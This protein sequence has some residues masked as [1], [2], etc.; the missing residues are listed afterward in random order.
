MNSAG[1]LERV[2]TLQVTLESF[3]PHGKQPFDSKATLAEGVP[4]PPPVHNNKSDSK[5]YDKSDIKSQLKKDGSSSTNNENSSSSSEKITDPID[6]DEKDLVVKIISR[7]PDFPEEKTKGFNAR[8]DSTPPPRG[9]IIKKPFPAI[10]V[11][12]EPPKRSESEEGDQESKAKA[13]T[14]IT[15]PT[16]PVPVKVEVKPLTVS[17]STPNGATNEAP[18]ISITFDQPMIPLVDTKSAVL[19]V[20]NSNEQEEKEKKKE[21]KKQ[22]GGPPKIQFPAVMEPKHPGRWRWIDTYTLVFEVETRFR[23]C[24]KITVKVP[25][26]TKAI[27]TTK[28]GGGILKEDHIL[29]FQTPVTNFTWRIY[30]LDKVAAALEPVIL[31]TTDHEIEPEQAFLKS[32]LQRPRF[33]SYEDIPIVRVKEVSELPA[34]AQAVLT[35]LEQDHKYPYKTETSNHWYAFKPFK[36][37][38]KNTKYRVRVSGSASI[39]VEGNGVPVLSLETTL[40]TTYQPLVMDSHS[41]NYSDWTNHAPIGRPIYISIYFN[42]SID[43][44]HF[45]P[46]MVTVDPPFE[47]QVVQRSMLV[48]SR[49][50]T[51]KGIIRVKSTSIKVSLDENITDEFGQRLGKKQGFSF[52]SQADEVDE[53]SLSQSNPIVSNEYVI[54]DPWAIEQEGKALWSC[55]SFNY[56]EFRVVVYQLSPEDWNDWSCKSN[57][58]TQPNLFKTGTLKDRKVEDKKF[59]ISALRRAKDA[60]TEKTALELG[61]EINNNEPPERVYDYIDVDLSDAFRKAAEIT[62]NKSK[63]FQMDEEETK[64]SKDEKYK[65]DKNEKKTSQNKTEKSKTSSDIPFGHLLVCIKPTKRAI[66]KCNQHKK[67]QIITWVAHTRIGISN[68][69]LNNGENLLICPDLRTGI[70]LDGISCY[71]QFVIHDLKD[72]YGPSDFVLIP[73][74]TTS[75]GHATFNPSTYEVSKLKLREEG[76]KDKAVKS[77]DMVLLANRSNGDSMFFKSSHWSRNYYNYKPEIIYT[78]DSRGLYRPKEEVI[79]RGWYRVTKNK[80]IGDPKL[81]AQVPALAYAYPHTTN[82]VVYDPLSN[83]IHEESMTI[84]DKGEIY[85][86]FVI[87]DNCNLGNVRITFL[88]HAHTIRVEEFRR[89]E[90][91][92]ESKV[93][94]SVLPYLMAPPSLETA[95]KEIKKWQDMANKK[96]KKVEF[97]QRYYQKLFEFMKAKESGTEDKEEEKEKE[98]KEDDKLSVFSESNPIESYVV[99]SA[100]ASYYAG[101]GLESSN[102]NWIVT[103]NREAYNPLTFPPGFS[104]SSIL[105]WNYPTNNNHSG[106]ADEKGS[107][108]LKINFAGQYAVPCV[109]S[110]NGEATV[111]DLNNQALVTSQKCIVH[112][113][114]LYVGIKFHKSSL[115]KGEINTVFVVVTDDKGKQIEGVDVMMTCWEQHQS[116]EEASYEILQSRPQAS[117]EDLEQDIDDEMEWEKLDA[118][119][120][121]LRQDRVKYAYWEV[122]CDRENTTIYVSA[123]VRDESGRFNM[124]TSSF[125]ALAPWSYLAKLPNQPALDPLIKNVAIQTLNITTDKEEYYVN[126]TP[127]IIIES[128]FAPCNGFVY[129]IVENSIYHFEH[130][131]IKGLSED[132]VKSELIKKKTKKDKGKDKSNNSKGDGKQED[133]KQLELVQQKTNSHSIVVNLPKI[134]KEL[135]PQFAVKAF[136]YGLAIRDLSATVSR[137][138]IAVSEERRVP[139]SKEGR[140]LNIE[141]QLESELCS[142]GSDT[143]AKISV[144]DNRV[145]LKDQPVEDAEVHLIVVDESILDLSMYD[146]ISALNT[147]YTPSIVS[148]IGLVYNQNHLMLRNLDVFLDKS[149][150][151]E[152]LRKEAEEAEKQ[153]KAIP[154]PVPV[155]MSQSSAPGSS[156]PP[157]PPPPPS[158]SPASRPCSSKAPPPP[159]SSPSSSSM[160]LRRD[161]IMEECEREAAPSRK[162]KSK[163]NFS[164]EERRMRSSSIEVGGKT[165]EEGGVAKTV[166]Q[167]KLTIRK[168]FDPLSAFLRG[169]TDPKGEITF[170]FKLKDNLTRYRVWAIAASHPSSTVD[171][172]DSLYDSSLLDDKDNEKLEPDGN[173]WGLSK[174]GLTVTSPFVLRPSYPRFLN[175]GD[176]GVMLNCVVQNQ[177]NKEIE[178]TVACRVQN[179]VFN[180]KQ[181]KSKTEVKA[182]GYKLTIP[183]NRRQLITF[184]IDAKLPGTCRIQIGAVTEGFTDAT[185]HSIPVYTPSTSEAFATYNELSGDRKEDVQIQKLAKPFNVSPYFGGLTIT[186]SSTLLLGLTDAMQYLWLYHF[187]CSEQI[188][189]KVLS[190]SAMCNHLF[191]FKQHIP[192]SHVPKAM[193]HWLQILERRQRKNG[194]FGIWSNL[195]KEED[196]Y[197]WFSL[198]VSHALARAKEKGYCIPNMFNLALTNVRRIF[199]SVGGFFSRWKY[200]PYENSMLKSYVLYVR[201]IAGDDVSTESL[202][203]YNENKYHTATSIAWCLRGIGDPKDD[204]KKKKAVESIRKYI[205]EKIVETAET[206]RFKESEYSISGHLF[207]HSTTRTDAIVLEAIIHF[208]PELLGIKK[209]LVT[210]LMK[211]LMKV[212]SITGWRTTQENSF[213]L[214]AMDKYMNTYEKN[215][216]NYTEQV[217]IGDQYVKEQRWEGRTTDSVEVTVPMS[218]ILDQFSDGKKDDNNNNNLNSSKTKKSKTPKSPNSE[219]KMSNTSSA[220]PESKKAPSF[221]TATDKFYSNLAKGADQVLPQLDLPPEESGEKQEKQPTKTVKEPK[222][223]KEQKVKLKVVEEDDGEEKYIVPEDQETKTITISKTGG[224]GM[225]YYQFGINVRST[226]SY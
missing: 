55:L 61:G 80:K 40:F 182:L 178:V 148:S 176:T 140:K 212:R 133:T 198:H 16:P 75:K 2:D 116:L 135:I 216:P 8:E 110:V 158:S 82:V 47:D 60:T 117:K 105:V 109:L 191:A 108:Y 62:K 184:P 202:K 188:A 144:K 115:K 94:S 96:D 120:K 128:P 146:I 43:G 222:E 85:F 10:P 181:A 74:A 35:L 218:W 104:A 24:S 153:K 68:T 59:K 143:W 13:D 41:P 200:S 217:W 206:A 119:Q 177:L 204:P 27:E 39:S 111:M 101:G 114:K 56:S 155:F 208:G 203:F 1:S 137:P 161:D 58:F 83:K 118:K 199:G 7:L 129:V 78:F 19:I 224:L 225:L 157:L 79:I 45:N 160:S 3:V 196:D 125:T 145:G 167:P 102:V 57:D 163:A 49:Y 213:A 220:T 221:M 9:T 77:Y 95:Y 131:S 103:C 66:F 53:Q 189:S 186:T 207:V 179:A 30:G 12:T 142:P 29:S 87:P 25:K 149:K 151:I 33:I 214:I 192:E 165:E 124:A 46:D 48:N 38:T 22:E 26:G 132:E 201:Q 172:T 36:P 205:T 211:G 84:T 89:P 67:D 14:R 141:I 162:K 100:K 183:A 195:E 185:E 73:K 34:D 122:P 126:D 223:K 173:R 190:F 97:Q 28:E 76:K 5:L 152:Q 93:E 226:R 81:G 63:L 134:Q 70:P 112:P 194:T 180:K 69:P 170:K 156:L 175:Y 168:D 215:V 150:V 71:Q 99:F 86:K 32:H 187:E 52:I 121:E 15:T 159:C 164:S 54:L 51:I 139:V 98:D 197:L 17:R 169:N 64:D 20:T 37:L 127:K 154:K 31:L 210:K 193:N 18:T 65:K 219:K 130:F 107:H 138:A 50:I 174:A 171:H 72:Y 136:A 11:P 147:F 6:V 209:D 4:P 88:S 113:S 91:K 166:V 42:N 123:A 23:A 106:I 92:I 90:F 21:E 44:N